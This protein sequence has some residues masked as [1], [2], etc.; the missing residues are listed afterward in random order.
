MMQKVAGDLSG[1]SKAG[2]GLRVAESVRGRDN[3]EKKKL[4]QELKEIQQAY[5]KQL[6]TKAAELEDARVLIY[7]GDQD[8]QSLEAQ[9][10]DLRHELKQVYARLQQEETTSIDS[11]NGNGMAQSNV[12]GEHTN[13]TGVT[14]RAHNTYPS[15]S[16]GL[17]AGEI[18]SPQVPAH[19]E[20]SMST[21]SGGTALSLTAPIEGEVS[22][23]ARVL[24]ATGKRA[25]EWRRVYACVSAGKINMYE[26]AADRYSACMPRLMIDVTYIF[27]VRPVTSADLRSASQKEIERSF[28]LIYDLHPD[29]QTHDSTNISDLVSKEFRRTCGHLL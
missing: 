1:K 14:F 18:V 20:R 29:R 4:Q 24:G 9:I 7:N 19:V 15:A 22:V 2:K 3:V 8:R 17:H 28:Q 21:V 5:E 10:E 13:E 23:Q 6:A 12:A 16:T 25:R 11:L 27:H 26:R